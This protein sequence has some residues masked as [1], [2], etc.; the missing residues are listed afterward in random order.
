MERTEW[1]AEIDLLLPP[2]AVEALSSPAPLS[3]S[4][5][6]LMEESR[7]RATLP[8]LLS[9]R[10]TTLEQGR[11]FRGWVVWT[12]EW[13]FAAAAAMATLA[14]GRYA[15]FLAHSTS[16]LWNRLSQISLPLLVSATYYLLPLSRE[17]RSAHRRLLEA[18]DEG[19]DR[20]VAADLLRLDLDP[21][22]RYLPPECRTKWDECFY[23]GQISLIERAVEMG[24]HTT[25]TLALLL[26]PKRLE[27]ERRPLTS[28]ARDEKTRLLLWN[29]KVHH[30]I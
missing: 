13:G 14:I 1:D 18:F 22:A 24:L 28:F 9:R 6:F 23:P 7:K 29:L 21:N 16:L 27:D 5:L 11:W 2:L 10:I 17:N 25:V 19:R 15:L 4:I 8:S 12:A 30:S 26:D 3:N 20:K